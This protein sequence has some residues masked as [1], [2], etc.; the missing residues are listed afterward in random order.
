MP[1]PYTAQII[2][3][4]R[5][6]KLVEAAQNGTVQQTEDAYQKFLL[7]LADMDLLVSPGSCSTAVSCALACFQQPTAP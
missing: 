4:C 7:T 2:Y 6:L 3:H 5:W 1:V